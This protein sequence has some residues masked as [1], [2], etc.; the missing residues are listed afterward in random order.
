MDPL[1][2]VLTLLDPAAYLSAGL[3][4]GGSWAVR[5]EPPAGVKFNAVSRGSCLLTV[6]GVPGTIPL[7]EGDCFLLTR[8]RGFVLAGD[9]E[10]FPVPAG[11]IF[12]AAAG[13]PARA[14]TGDEVALLGGG[15]DFGARARDLLLDAL[16]PVVHVPAGT[17]EAG[18]LRWAIGRIDAELREGRPASGLLAEHLAVVM[19]IEI[20]R[21]RLSTTPAPAS[22]WLAGLGDP[23]VA[24]ALRAVHARPAYPWTV[25]GLAREAAVS[26]STLAA[27]FRALVGRGPLDYL[28]GWRLELAA[29]RLRRGT[30]P[31]AVIA[32]DIGYGSESALSVAF[33]RVLGESPA[34]YRSRHSAGSRNQRSFSKESGRSSPAPSAGSGR[35]AMIERASSR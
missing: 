35:S 11:L 24:A 3:V 31:I 28:T 23:V 12:A 15:F 9:P 18:T 1:Q 33:K 26:R 20:L 17:R 13:G 21:L 2:D 14:G 6:D 25:A 8:P 34:A 16:P 27:R 7:A 19:L 5:F 29:D 10:A 22:G 30:D 32:R 4:A